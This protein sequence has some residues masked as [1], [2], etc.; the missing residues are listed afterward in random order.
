MPEIAKYGFIEVGN[1]ELDS[2]LRSGIRFRL[3]EC[4]D[5]KVIYAFVVDDKEK[6]I[7][8]CQEIKTTLQ[9]RMQRYQDQAGAGTNERIAGEIRSCLENENK[10]KILALLTPQNFYYHDLNIDFVGGLENPLIEKINPLW[11]RQGIEH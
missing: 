11:N 6:Y 10:V 9:K 1:W 7:G 2:T 4:Q 5:K 8:I 3:K